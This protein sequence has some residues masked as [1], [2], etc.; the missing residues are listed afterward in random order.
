MTNKLG[1]FAEQIAVKWLIKNG[2]KIIS[3]NFWLAR[4]GEIDIIAKKGRIYHFIEVKALEKTADF[5]PE[6]HFTENKQRKIQ[7]LAVYFA[8]KNKIDDYQID[9]LTVEI[10]EKNAKIKLYQNI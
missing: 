10:S 4:Y 2:F 7:N 5:S 3:Q 9:L 6:M 1:S 8:N